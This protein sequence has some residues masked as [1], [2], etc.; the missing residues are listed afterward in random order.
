MQP[1]HHSI[2]YCYITQESKVSPDPYLIPPLC[3]LYLTQIRAR[4]SNDLERIKD[5]TPTDKHQ[6]PPTGKTYET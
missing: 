4:S 1:F 5:C 6:A 2:K 3:S